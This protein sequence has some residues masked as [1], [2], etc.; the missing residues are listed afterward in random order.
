MRLPDSPHAGVLALTAGAARR[1]LR[2]TAGSWRLPPDTTDD[3]EAITGELAA[4]ALEHSDS[5]TVT[6]TCALTADTVTIGVTDDGGSRRTPVIP[7]PTGSPE[8]ECERG[9]GL[10]IT[11]ALATRWGTRRT[12]GGLTVWAGVSVGVASGAPAGTW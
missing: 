12:S 6:V 4:N 5:S 9:R 7:A 11:D 8:P 3:L 10:L 2:A 1:Y